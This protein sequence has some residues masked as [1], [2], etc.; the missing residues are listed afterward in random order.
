MILYVYHM[1]ER[2]HE[3]KF[4]NLSAQKFILALQT[5]KQ[6]D[7]ILCHFWQMYPNNHFLSRTNNF[8]S[9]TDHFIARTK[10]FYC[11]DTL[12]TL[13][14]VMKK[15]K[16]LQAH[17]YEFSFWFSKY[18]GPVLLHLYESWNKCH[19]SPQDI[20]TR[21]KISYVQHIY[22]KLHILYLRTLTVYSFDIVV[23]LCH[24]THE[25]ILATQAVHTAFNI[26]LAISFHSHKTTK[27]SFN[28]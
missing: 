9:G 14:R 11:R 13:H 22:C 6:L 18:D 3:R 15:G 1:K 12:N 24:Y 10:L 4:F 27:L 20:R 25:C 26:N 19:M 8:M 28:I 23:S 21:S 7:Y 5:V 16:K 17:L 2:A